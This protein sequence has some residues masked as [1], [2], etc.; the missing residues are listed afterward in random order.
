MPY[1]FIHALL[2]LCS[3]L[4]LAIGCSEISGNENGSGTTEAFVSEK[5]NGKYTLDHATS[6]ELRVM[7]NTV[8]NFSLMIKRQPENIAAYNE[9][10]NLLENHINRINKY[11]SLDKNTKTELCKNLNLINEKIPALRQSDVALAAVAEKEINQ[12]F[13]KI[14]SSFA[15]KN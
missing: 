13:S 11:C 8:I 12:L 15:F 9:Y 14:D 5:I 3:V 6:E 4:F 7:E 1:S 2:L 10:G